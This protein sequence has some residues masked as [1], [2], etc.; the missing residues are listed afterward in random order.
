MLTIIKVI[1][2]INSIL[3]LE[4]NIYMKMIKSKLYRR[5]LVLHR[6]AKYND[7]K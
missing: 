7:D 2:L 4:Y 6:K 5:V 3:R 1:I